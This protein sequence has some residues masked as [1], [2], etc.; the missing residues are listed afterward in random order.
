MLVGVAFLL[1]AL[2]TVFLFFQ[3]RLNQQSAV[4]QKQNQHQII[5]EISRL[6]LMSNT[7][8]HPFLRYEHAKEADLRLQLLLQDYGHG[9]TQAEASLRLEG[10]TLTA[11]QETV[12]LTLQQAQAPFLQKLFKEQPA[13]DLPQLNRLSGLTGAVRGAVEHQRPPAAATSV[14]AGDPGLTSKRRQSPR[15][16]GS[17]S[18]PPR[19]SDLSRAARQ[20]ELGLEPLTSED[21]DEEVVMDWA[22]PLASS[23]RGH[24]DDEYVDKDGADLVI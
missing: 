6:V 2:I 13:L 5:Q 3:L 23:A 14:E 17:P 19:E 15:P 12:T 24:S 7:Q 11:L 22:R 16:S 10:G 21:E 18:S 8:Q 4:H 20:T 9:P 1:L